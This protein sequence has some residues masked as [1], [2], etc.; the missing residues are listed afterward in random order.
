MNTIEYN[1]NDI[2]IIDNFLEENEYNRIKTILYSPDF[3][4]SKNRINGDYELDGRGNKI[5]RT[6]NEMFN[7]QMTHGTYLDMDAPK[8]IPG[9]KSSFF[10]EI[11]PILL[12]INPFHLLRVKANLT[13]N[14]QEKLAGNFHVDVGVFS[15]M[16]M[17]AIMYFTTSNGPTEFK[18]GRIVNSVEN[19]LVIFPNEFLHT[20]YRSTNTKERIVLNINWIDNKRFDCTKD[21][22]YAKIEEKQ[23]EQ[24][25]IID[26]I[27]N[28]RN[29]SN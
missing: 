16:G 15:G 28:G 24:N 6:I 23:K 26:N 20:G 21:E 22:L 4:W 18:N 3:I 9:I 5:D 10:K 17:T 11:R 19:R 29:S 7:I 13:F 14:H 8:R 2:T 12:K 1:I 27:R 25:K